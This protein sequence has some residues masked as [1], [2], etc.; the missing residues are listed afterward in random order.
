MI[1]ISQTDDKLII[2]SE[3]LLVISPRIKNWLTSQDVGFVLTQR[4]PSEVTY[5]SQKINDVKFLD[6]VYKFLNEFEKDVS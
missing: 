2:K 1:K 4:G 5:E 3:D 6:R